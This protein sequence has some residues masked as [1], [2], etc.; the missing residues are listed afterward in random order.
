M[1]LTNVSRMTHKSDQIEK[2]K[3]LQM[4][5]SNY[6]LS[7]PIPILE[8]LQIHVTSSTLHDIAAYDDINHIH[9]HII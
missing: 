5:F 1:N 8:K 2:A 7:L 9:I 6:I 4:P 3:K